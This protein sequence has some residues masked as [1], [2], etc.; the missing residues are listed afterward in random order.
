M[1]ELD[2]V[3]S[4]VDAPFEGL[5]CEYVNAGGFRLVV[6]DPLYHLEA[7]RARRRTRPRAPSTIAGNASCANRSV[8]NAHHVNQPSRANGAKLDAT[9]GRGVTGSVDGARWQ[10]GLSVEEL[11]FDSLAER[12]R[13]G[14]IV[15][16]SVTKSNYAPEAR[17]GAAGR[18]D[19]YGGALLPLDD[20]DL[21]T[22]E[23]ARQ[24]S[25]SKGRRTA[26]KQSEAAKKAE[27]ERKTQASPRTSQAAAEQSE[28]Q[29]KHSRALVAILRAHPE[30]LTVSD[31]E[32]KLKAA[33]GTMTNGHHK[34]VPRVGRSGGHHRKE[35]PSARSPPRASL[36]LV[37]TE[38]PP[39][40]AGYP[41]P[42]VEGVTP[43]AAQ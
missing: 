29:L 24:Q 4:V 21:E 5:A 2:A 19:N 8:L 9:S 36:V 30:G 27:E 26:E 1:Q 15:T 14:E 20:S 13:L 16:F 7:R 28:R 32:S 40:P 41:L 33:L 12:Q 11:K 31:V 25:T 38:L 6:V 35:V 10:C 22:I 3:G 39:H 42:D 43:E 17:A 18:D 34:V 37:E 23:L